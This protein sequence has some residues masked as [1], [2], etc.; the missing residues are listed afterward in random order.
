MN[1]HKDKIWILITRKLSGESTTKENERLQQWLNEDPGNR[2]FYNR[3]KSSWSRNPGESVDS[4]SLSFQFNYEN[5]LQKL[6][7]KLDQEDESVHQKNDFEIKNRFKQKKSK[8]IYAWK[9]V[10]S[11]LVMV[12]SSIIYLTILQGWDQPA[13]TTYA[14]TDVEQRIITL[15]DGSVVRLNRNSILEVSNKSSDESRTI[16]LDGEAFFDVVKDSLNPFVVE[17][18]RVKT[19]VLGTAFNVSS[20]VQE[21]GV[22]VTLVSGQV[23]LEKMET[24]ESLYLEPGEESVISP[25]KEGFLKRKLD[26][27]KRI[28][29]ISYCGLIISL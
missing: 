24:N 6:R 9:L 29:R 19:Q 26:V 2:E 14:T 13:T 20:F 15:S 22:M 10:A 5:G 27:S 4:F 23:R 18:K 17:S 21:R 1:K 28:S 12:M 25:E 11:I 16:W 3:L 8:G 7:N